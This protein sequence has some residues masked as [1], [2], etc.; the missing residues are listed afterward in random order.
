MSAPVVAAKA[1]DP[2]KEAV[3]IGR[4]IYEIVEQPLPLIEVA[5]GEW[6]ATLTESGGDV[7]SLSLGSFVTSKA[8]NLLKAFIPELMPFHEFRGYASA[9]ALAASEPRDPETAR[10]APTGKQVRKALSAGFRINGIDIWNDVTKLL[11]PTVAQTILGEG[12]LRLMERVEQPSPKPSAQA[13]AP[14]GSRTST[15]PQSRTSAESG[16]SSRTDLERSSALAP[17]ES[18]GSRSLASAP[19]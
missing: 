6:F 16:S 12:A 8:Y 19:S 10:N 18:E 13:T 15:D 1:Y 5:L 7:E 3:H 11:D 14:T 2:E 17:M 9:A 4:F